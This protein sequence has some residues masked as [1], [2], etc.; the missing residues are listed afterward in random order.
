MTGAYVV[1]G[2]VVAALFAAAG[3]WGT[4]RWYRVEPSARFWPLLRFAQVALLVQLVFGAGL[5]LA[6][7]RPEDD[8]YY[9]YALLPVLISFAAE[10]L[11]ISAAETV[12]EAR[13]LESAQQVGGLPVAEQRSVALAIVRRELGVMALAA[14]VIAGLLIRALFT[15]RGL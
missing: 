12:L 3:A 13:G 8:L 10:Q 7:R 6:G 4:W 11:R 15:S 2:A 14:L 1:V 9:V 5:L